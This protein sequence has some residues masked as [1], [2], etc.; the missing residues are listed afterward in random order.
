MTHRKSEEVQDVR[1]REAS[2]REVAEQ[3][4][5]S[6]GDATKEQDASNATSTVQSTI[7]TLEQEKAAL[8]EEVAK[9]QEVVEE[10]QAVQMM[11]MQEVDALSWGHS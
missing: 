1:K 11:R 6:L 5:A 10:L 2:L 9:K 7:A 8:K 4:K 3:M